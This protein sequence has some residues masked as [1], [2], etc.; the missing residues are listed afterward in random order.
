MSA[1]VLIPARYHSTRFPG[2]PL[3][4]LKGIPIIQHVYRNS[5][6]SRLADDVIVATDNEAILE[7]VLS[8]G[9]KAVMTSGDHMSGTDRIAEISRS[10]DYDIIVNVQGDEPLIK[11][12]MIDD[13]ISAL[14]DGRAAIAT[15]AKKITD[16]EEIFDPNVVKVV[17][18]Q[19]GFA[20]YFSRAPIPYHRD[21]WKSLKER[22]AHAGPTT[23]STY[24]CYKH[25]GIYSYRKNVL[26]ELSQTPPS[27][28]ERIEKLEQL[29]ALEN[30]FRIKVRETSSETFGV[31]TPD[32][33]ERI[34]KC[35][36]TSL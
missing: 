7:K 22:A 25:I 35:L 31:D 11:P 6:G 14:D 17:C 16:P 27:R 36:N 13:V 3:A 26:L 5:S 19:D 18:N 4:P 15:L 9:G 33:L 28:L 29:R 34:E 23:F 20:F 21:E 8:F 1:I 2:K 12:D 24:D 32:D 30:N 10:L